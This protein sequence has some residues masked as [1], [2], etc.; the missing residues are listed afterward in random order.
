MVPITFHGMTAREGLDHVYELQD[1]GLT[2][3]IDFEWAYNQ[4]KFGE[5]RHG[6]YCEFRFRDPKLATF[7]SLKWQTKTKT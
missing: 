4:E 7:Y 5:D 3:D 1:S 2:R 6:K